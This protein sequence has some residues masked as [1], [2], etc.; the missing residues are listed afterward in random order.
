MKRFLVSSAV[1]CASLCATFATTAIAQPNDEWN[2][3]PRIFAVNALTPHVTSMP[4]STVEEAVKGDRH[5]SEWYQTLS[6]KWKF[7][8]VEKPAQRNNDFYKDNYDVSGWNEI[9]VPS[10]WQLFGYDHPIYTNV[11][12]P[13]AQNNNVSAPGAPTNFNPVGHYRRNFTI[14]EKWSGKRIRLHFEGVESAYYVWV[15]GN[16]V[17]YAEDSFTDHE[18]DINKYLRKGENNVSVQVFRWCDGSWL[19]DQ[20][21]IRLAGIFRDVYLYAVPEVHIQDFQIDATLTNNYTD[22]LLKTTAWIYNS[23]GSASSEFTVELSLYN[24]KG[25]E[26]ISPSAQKVSGIGSKGEKSV[27]FELPITKPDRWS[28]E[29]PNLYTAVLAIKDASGK[30]IQVE[31]NKIGFR[32]IEIKKDNGAPRLYVNGMP[33]KFHGVDRHELD[34]DDGRAVTYDRMEKDVILMKRFNINALRM[35]HYPNNPYMYDLCDKYGIYVIDEANVESHGANNSLPKNSDDWRAPAVD[36]MNSMVQRDKNHPSIIL[37]SLGNEAGNGNVF[38]SERERAHQIDSTRFVHYEGD[39][40]N[41]D[42]NSWMYFGPDAVRN[43]NDANKPI[44]LCEYEHAMGNSV[45]DLQ[46]YMDAFYAN[47]RSFGGFIWDF[48]D[49][50]L[51]HKGTPYFEFGGMWGDWQNDD[52]FCANGLVFPDR[53]LQPEIWEVKYQYA[54]VRVKNVD[55][56]KGKIQIESRYLYKNLGD[57]LDGYWSIKENGKVIK[58]GKLNGSQMNVGPNQKKE[59]TIDMPKI[60]TTVGAEYFLDLDFRLKNDE[61]WAKAGYSIAHEQFGIDLGQLWSTEIDISTLPTYKVNKTN[62]LEIEGKDFKIRFDEKNGTLASYVLGND[63]IIKNGGIPNFW[64]APIDNDKGFNMEKG[65]GEWRKASLKRNVTSEVKEVSQQE[66]QV[67][68]NFSFPDVGS[69]KM[70]MTYYVYGS[71]DI[72]VSY[73]LNPDGSKSYLP[74]VGTLFTVPGGY[75]KVRWFG[76]GPDENYMGR[77]RGS[78]MG[79]YSTVADSMTVKYMEIGETGQ[80]TDVKW[81]TLTNNDGKGLMIVGNPRMEFSAQHYTPEQLS[82]VKL[83]WELKRDKDITLRVDLHQM[84]VGGINSWGAEPLDAYKLKANREYSHTFRLAPIRKKLNDPTEY[85]LLGFRNFGWNKEIAPAK[86]GETEIEKIYENQPDKDITEDA[87]E[88]TEG[89]TPIL[90]SGVKMAN[91]AVRDYSVF[92]MQGRIVAKFSTVGIEDLQA[93]TTAAV[94]RSGT[95]LVKT[96]TGTAYRINVK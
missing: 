88:E 93:K 70:K 63:T 77:N 51:R 30:V 79:L 28:A 95:Y 44:M 35:S 81:A 1:T 39:W 7:F 74:N 90:P 21:F 8:H 96:K 94:K 54:Q 65:H 24:D 34:P 61:L 52:N 37:W 84:G 16:Y 2:G 67:T 42:V 23:T 85:S 10:S 73:T 60:E 45:G 12:Y 13:W 29:T 9:P 64:R 18:F 17:G 15:N 11:V 36:R 41:A 5:A 87:N 47:P 32:K 80:R 58:E 19:E 26:V 68:F 27:H 71:G 62:G 6:G 86:Y 66:T 89:R 43:Y 56:A 82:N 50:G 72:V 83:P 59:I 31:S 4:Y 22:G 75:E 69:T 57:F 38:A 48:I 92:D 78:F 33:V 49:Q 14:P 40:N 3:K 20:D 76:R 53:A 55:A 25:T 46:E 91:N